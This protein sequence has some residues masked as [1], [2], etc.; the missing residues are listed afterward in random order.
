MKAGNQAMPTRDGAMIIGN[1]ENGHVKIQRLNTANCEVMFCPAWAA[2]V[3]G[4][5]YYVS[6]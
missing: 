3:N 6:T 5:P 1:T 2:M 4:H